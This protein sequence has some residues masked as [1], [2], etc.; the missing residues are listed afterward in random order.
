MSNKE[1]FEL[2]DKKIQEA[3]KG[4]GEKRIEAQHK[5]GNINA[6][7]LRLANVWKYYSIKVLFRS[8]A[9]L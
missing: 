9:C 2:L 5:R 7:N 8:W 4:G 6:E 1:K 3:L